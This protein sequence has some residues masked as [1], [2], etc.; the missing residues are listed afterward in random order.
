MPA[1]PRLL[2]HPG[3]VDDR[4][5]GGEASLDQE[6]AVTPAAGA[7]PAFVDAQQ[8]LLAGQARVI[9]DVGQDVDEFAKLLG[10]LG[11]GR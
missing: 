7:H 3:C 10:E 11:K 9:A 6:V 8:I 5:V 2:H 1:G 4:P